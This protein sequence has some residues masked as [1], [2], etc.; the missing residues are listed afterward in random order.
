MPKR[1]A[2]EETPAR[3]KAGQRAEKGLCNLQQILS[4]CHFGAIY[5][6][7][8]SASITK[9]DKRGAVDLQGAGDGRIA[10]PQVQERLDDLLFAGKFGVLA[11]SPFGAAQLDTLR[12]LAGQGVP[13]PLRDQS[14]LNLS[15]KAER[16]CE[17]F[18]G[19]IVAQAPALFDCP[20]PTSLAQAVRHDAENHKEA[21]AQTG[22]LGGDDGVVACDAL[23]LLAKF[24]LVE[25]LHPACGLDD[26]VIN[27]DRRVLMGAKI[28]DSEHLVFDR[29][30]PS[31]DSDIAKIHNQILLSIFSEVCHEDYKH[32]SLVRRKLQ[33][34]G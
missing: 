27:V 18:A 10:V 29:L 21:P 8:Y 33:D 28:L 25:V 9:S 5:G 7:F 1:A 32:S 13:R 15:G 19:E 23:E 6:P 22:D 26:P 4:A 30:L 12:P 31:A 2:E 11:K 17:D 3:P 24:A 14:P 20:D 16:K 34:P